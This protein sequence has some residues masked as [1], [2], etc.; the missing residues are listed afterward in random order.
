MS[1]QF[2]Q[3]SDTIYSVESI[4]PR[5]LHQDVD[6]NASS[7]IAT[8]QRS[9]HISS[10]GD[11]AV[12]QEMNRGKEFNNSSK[13]L[14]DRRMDNMEILKEL[15]RPELLIAV[16]VLYFIGVALKNTKK[17]KDEYIPLLLGILGIAISGMYIVANMEDFTAKS[18]LMAVFA[19]VTQGVLI[20]GA[21]VYVN[22]LIKQAGKEPGTGEKSKTE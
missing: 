13:K 3:H 21:S 11:N 5:S 4:K 7:L 17:I 2:E 22:Q 20:S 8:D 15:I 6:L 1:L 16:P 19:A 9:L 12:N 10:Q 14:E 18:I